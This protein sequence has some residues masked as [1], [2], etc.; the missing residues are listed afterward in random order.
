M[1]L[2]R[3]VSILASAV[4]LTGCLSINVGTGGTGPLREKVVFGEGDEKILLLDLDGTLVEGAERSSF[5][6]GGR[7]SI[8]ARTREQLE[9]AADDDDIR[10][11]LL[12]VRSPGGTVT[13]SEI[14]HGEIA[15]YKRETGVP[16]IAQF[17][18]VA[19]S[20]A[21]Y[22]AMTADHV[23]AYPTTITGSIGVIFAGL[24]LAGL[25][26]KVGVENQT[27]VT[28]SF[29]D[30]GSPL[31]RMND[32]E[33]AQLE[34]VIDDL[35]DRFLTVVDEGRPGLDRARVEELADGR[36]YSAA[37]ALDAGLV[38]SIGDLPS[39]VDLAR[40]R[41]GLEEAQVIVYGRE[42]DRRNNLF[43]A[44]AP[45]QP[46]AGML[47]RSPADALAELARP[48]FLYLWSPAATT[49]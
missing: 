14:L 8:V 9:K 17:M 31:R 16:V 10:A 1:V 23:Q 33:R 2:V 44:V 5:G 32:A 22:L 15:R 38:D 47:G 3:L 49:P 30:A 18:G 13:A 36:I 34:S 27:M 7:D 43:S 19:T 45:V 6:F 46:E 29:K 21:Y 41:A 40:E 26:D 28:G 48:A 42:N 35:F 20:G 11:L 39:A 37:Q 24:N 4:L 12:R 25:L